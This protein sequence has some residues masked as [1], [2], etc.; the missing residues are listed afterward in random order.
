MMQGGLHV[1]ESPYFSLDNTWQ[2]QG[3]LPVW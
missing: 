3:L 2:V 1:G